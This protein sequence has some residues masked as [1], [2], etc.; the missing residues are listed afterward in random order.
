MDA[1]FFGN[2]AQTSLDGPYLARH[3]ALKAGVPIETPALTINRLC[4]SGFETL[5]QGALTL[6]AGDA[7]VAMVNK[8][9]VTRNKTN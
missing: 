1:V 7:S 6:K 4:G 8:N 9:L 3:A 5:I 2:V